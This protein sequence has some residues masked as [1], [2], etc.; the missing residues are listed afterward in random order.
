MDT[1]KS[2]MSTST[3]FGGLEGESPPWMLAVKGPLLMGGAGL[4]QIDSGE[5]EEWIARE[6]EL[7]PEH[8]Q[9]ELRRCGA[10]CFANAGHSVREI[11]RENGLGRGETGELQNEDAESSSARAP[12][13]VWGI[14][15][16]RSVSGGF[17]AKSA[18]LER[19]QVNTNT[20]SAR[21]SS[22]RTCLIRSWLTYG[23]GGGGTEDDASDDHPHLRA[24]LFR[25][26][27]QILRMLA[28]G[29]T[30]PKGSPGRSVTLA[31]REKHHVL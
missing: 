6:V 3:G 31:R 21:S 28:L 8:E 2:V 1:S 22:G 20:H 11:R 9:V 10:D 23:C 16:P 24:S 30:L 5:Y 13:R 29:M 7:Q 25:A 17:Y 18:S 12:R 27:K 4:A 14:L 26:C 15:P 19:L